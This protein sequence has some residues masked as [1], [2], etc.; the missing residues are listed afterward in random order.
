MKTYL[1]S[2]LISLLGA[3]AVL[4]QTAARVVV[5][6][7]PLLPKNGMDASTTASGQ[8]VFVDLAS[9]QLVVVADSSKPGGQFRFDMTDQ[10]DSSV[11]SSVSSGGT[12]GYTYSYSV[13]T[14]GAGRPATH[15]SVLMPAGAV[16]AGLAGAAILKVGT[17]SVPNRL[18]P[19]AGN[20]TMI[21]W[22]PPFP[23]AVLDGVRLQLTSHYLPGFTDAFLQSKAANPISANALASLPADAAQQVQPFL[24]PEW[25]SVRTMAIAPIFPPGVA[26][27]W[28][29]ANFQLGING[30]VRRKEL[31]ASSVVATA[32]LASLDAY[33]RTD[34]DAPLPKLPTVAAG[35]ET[36]QMVL[37]A[38]HAA[39]QQ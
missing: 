37:D 21:S 5:F 33:L 22:D 13:R 39:F 9:G 27:R 23:S 12:A 30:L 29:A 14:L 2:W 8:K 32:L 36:E 3:S 16:P 38:I 35:T 17:S 11:R 15:L 6:P 25:S 18:A 26:P 31:S 19:E 24:Q 4:A 1:R 7:A 34:T 10:T 20:L 28:I